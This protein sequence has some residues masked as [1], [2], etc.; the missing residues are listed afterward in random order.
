ML[1][2]GDRVTSS[3]DNLDDI[4]L[5]DQEAFADREVTIV[6]GAHTYNNCNLLQMGKEGDYMTTG[7]I[8]PTSSNP[9]YILKVK[10]IFQRD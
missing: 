6:Y 8:D 4:L 1:Y 7:Q 9:L 2:I 5:A 3:V 10:A